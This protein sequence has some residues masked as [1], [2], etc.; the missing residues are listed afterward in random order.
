MNEE[1]YKICRKLGWTVCDFADGTVELSQLIP[2]GLEYIE[3]K[4]DEEDFCWEVNA[5][6]DNFD[7]DNYAEYEIGDYDVP[8]YEARISF[9]EEVQDL[10]DELASALYKAKRDLALA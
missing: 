9:A 8:S 6:A 10:L 5:Y 3:F 2:C 1:Y 4:V 7:I